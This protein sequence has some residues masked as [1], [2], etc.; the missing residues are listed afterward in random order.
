MINVSFRLLGLTLI[1][2][3]FAALAYDGV[4]MLANGEIT[5]TPARRLWL[6]L[7]A[8][9]F[10]STRDTLDASVPYLWN[11]IVTPLL[12]LPA[13]ALLGAFGSL[14]FLAGYRRQPPEIVSDF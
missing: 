13:W 7:S 3:S 4:R 11:T 10:E 8:G 14:I 1:T 12:L 2:L 9:T 5:A 6:T